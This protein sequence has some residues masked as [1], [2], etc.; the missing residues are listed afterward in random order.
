MQCKRRFSQVRQSLPGPTGE[1]NDLFYEPKGVFVCISPWNFPVAIFIGQ[2]AAALITGNSVLAKPSEHT[3][4]LGEIVADIFYD[5]GIPT[6]ALQLFHGN[7][8]VGQETYKLFR[9]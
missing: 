1:T 8:E 9:D 3:P 7:G 2:I 6:D 5:C 4:L